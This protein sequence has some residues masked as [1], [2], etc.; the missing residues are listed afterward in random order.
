M[1][2]NRQTQY[3]SETNEIVGKIP[4][5]IIRQGN[6]T[7]FATVALLLILTCFVNYQDTIRA[8]AIV[9]YENG[10]FTAQAL[11]PGKG[12]GKIKNGQKVLV[13]TDCYPEAEFGH[14][15]GTVS[16]IGSLPEKDG[17]PI[18]VS[19]EGTSSNYGI[20]FR[21]IPQMG[22]QIV[23]VVGEYP[24]ILKLVPPLKR[25]FQHEVY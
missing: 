3:S 8:R 25:Y 7:L 16:Q 20:R 2:R 4:P 10:R 9:H 17:Y 12:F 21:P 13:K 11:L 14:L 24:L 5:W 19:I 1:P 18:N 6:A 23:V 22:A 15:T